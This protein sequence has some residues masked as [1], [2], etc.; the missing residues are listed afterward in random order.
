MY[1][2][3]THAHAQSAIGEDEQVVGETLVTPIW[4]MGMLLLSML[5]SM[6][7]RSLLLAFAILLCCRQS[8][9][10]AR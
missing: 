3:H 4:A 10:L 1:N 7:R 6:R 8:E 2:L 5:P 9:I